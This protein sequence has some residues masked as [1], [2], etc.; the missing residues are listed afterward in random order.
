MNLIYVRDTRCQGTYATI[1]AA[2]QKGEGEP[3]FRVTEE[4]RIDDEAAP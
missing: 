1:V 4:L 3:M 2:K